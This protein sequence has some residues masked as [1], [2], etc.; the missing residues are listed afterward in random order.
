MAWYRPR[1]LHLPHLTALPPTSCA[2]RAV[3]HAAS[4][5]AFACHVPLP[6]PRGDTCTCR[7]HYGGLPI[8]P[9]IPP[10]FKIPRCSC[11][12][13][14][15]FEMQ[16]LPSALLLLDVDEV[17]DRDSH[18]WGGASGATAT[19]V[20]GGSA[21]G[22]GAGAG[23]AGAGAGAAMGGSSAGGVGAGGGAGG[24][25]APPTLPGA[26][27]ALPLP[28]AATP[29]AAPPAPGAAPP[30]AGSGGGS[31]SGGGGGGAAVDVAA[32]LDSG[33]MDWGSIMVYSCE[34][35]CDQSHEE[36]CLVVDAF[37]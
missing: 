23:G 20:G 29:G 36:F 3:L 16:V 2:L 14:R 6:V 7:Y 22:A 37:A 1:K 21:V 10:K 15:E 5:T 33:G 27:P 18:Q 4:A 17:A 34:E 31:G 26:G 28:P 9:A 13:K 24:C 12:A 30:A 35:S 19:G 32:L 8:W 11:G 25:A